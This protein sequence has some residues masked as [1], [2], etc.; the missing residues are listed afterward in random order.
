MSLTASLKKQYSGDEIFLLMG[1]PMNVQLIKDIGFKDDRLLKVTPNDC[2]IG[3]KTNQSKP[4]LV[5]DLVNALKSASQQTKSDTNQSLTYPSTSAAAKAIQADVA[6]ISVP[7]AYAAY[8]AHQALDAGLNVMLFSDNVTVEDEIALKLK[9]IQKNLLLMGPDCGTAI[10][11]GVGLA[12]ANQIRKGSIGIVAASG[13]GLQEVTVLI[14][15]FGGGI[16]Q[17]I[18][19]GGRDLSEKVGGLMMLQGIDILNADPETKVITLISKP[20]AASVYEKIL[21]KLKTV[22]KPVVIGFI[23]GKKPENSPYYHA[24]TLAEAAYLSLKAIKLNPPVFEQLTEQQKLDAAANKKEK[25]LIRGLYCGGTLCSEGISIARKNL[26]GLYSNVSKKPEEHLDDVFHSK[27]HCFV[28]LG[29]DIFTNGRPHPM[30]E[31]TI[32]LERILQ[33]ANDPHVGVLLLDFELGY[34]SH[35]DPTGT[36]LEALQSFKA[37]RPDVP[38]IAYVCGTDGDRQRLSDQEQKL[39]AIGVRLAS[40]HAQAIRYAVAIIQGGANRE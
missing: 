2:L 13:T 9:A 10:I 16:T 5:D 24:S 31:P 7:G 27:G 36:H 1:T 18:G 12:F 22:S 4:S 11:N 38:I 15:R 26:T 23:D 32:R 40:S 39:K 28:D 33:E 37:K 14:D 25:K 35:D 21:Q 17:A 34:G 30:I 19:T 6:V 3:I 20:P 8:E 29:D